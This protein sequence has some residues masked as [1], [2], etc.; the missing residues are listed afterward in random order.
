MK[1]W[2]PMIALVLALLI[3]RWLAIPDPSAKL[4]WNWLSWSGAAVGL[5]NGVYAGGMVRESRTWLGALLAGAVVAG[6]LALVQTAPYGLLLP[7][8]LMLPPGQVPQDDLAAWLLG[9]IGLL[10]VSVVA[11]GVGGWW[12]WRVHWAT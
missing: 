8:A 12:S 9:G 7:D 4:Y 10:P 3:G 11:G 1:W 2:G 6:G 5:V